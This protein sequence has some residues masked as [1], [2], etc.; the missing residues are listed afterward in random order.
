MYALK[1]GWAKHLKQIHIVPVFL[2]TDDP[3]NSAV[4]LSVDMKLLEQQASIIRQEWP[5][6]LEAHEKQNDME[7]FPC[8]TDQHSCKYCP[9]RGMCSGSTTEIPPGVTPF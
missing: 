1:M 8:T 4:P 2:D 6:L 3:A 9:F 7:A 5:L